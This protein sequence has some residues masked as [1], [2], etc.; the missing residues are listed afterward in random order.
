MDT[1]TAKPYHEYFEWINVAAEYPSILFHF[2]RTH[3]ALKGILRTTFHPSM[4]R[5]IIENNGANK[6][7]AVP[8]VSFCDLGLSELPVHMKK[9]GR[10]GIGMSKEWAMRQGL[11]PVAYVN[12]GSE[13]TN[14]LLDGI[15]TYFDHLNTTP[16]LTALSDLSDSYMKILNVQRYIKNYRGTLRRSG[17][18]DKIYTF[19]DER[20]WRYVLPLETPGL[21]P[22]VPINLISDKQQK[23]KWN[24][25]LADHKLTFSAND[26]KYLIVERESNVKTLRRHIQ[27]LS[28]YSEQ[29]KDHLESRIITAEQITTD[30]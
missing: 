23:E 19:A 7:F 12:Q 2:T 18:A 30:M 8:M 27:S 25:L 10:Y 22:F 26:I 11:N 17:K 21:F 9:Y 3:D 20:E 24:G 4:A 1:T 28:N 15:Q 5:E 29:E 14:H 6:E 13:F 16:N